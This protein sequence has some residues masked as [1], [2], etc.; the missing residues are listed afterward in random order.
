MKKILKIFIVMLILIFMVALKNNV[1]AL[2]Y[3]AYGSY[4]LTW[5]IESIYYYV[6]SSAET[7]SGIIS[8]A[9]Y[10]WVYTG[11]GYNKLYPNTR[12]YNML[13][14]AVDIYAVSNLGNSTTAQTN[15]FKWVGGV[16]TEVGWVGVNPPRT[17]TGVPG[18]NYTFAEIRINTPVFDNTNVYDEKKA[19][20]G[21]EFGHC[22]GLGHNPENSYSLMYNWRATRNVYTVQQVDQDVFNILY[23]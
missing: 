6:D 16:Q 3:P 15:T 22:W 14:T 9:A 7:Y 18:D 8:D 1:N 23:P 4:K 12:S 17:N 2:T 11:L 19:T 13:N 21:H 5:N 20:I 10:N